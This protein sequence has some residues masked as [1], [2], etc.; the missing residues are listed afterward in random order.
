[1][2]TSLE[3]RFSRGFSAGVH[4]TWSAFIDEASEIFNPSPGE[5]AVSQDSFN[6][7]ADRGRS[8][9]DRPHRFAGNFVYELPWYREQHGFV[10]HVLGGWQINSSFSFQSGAP[11][12]PLNGSDPTGAL[13][14]IDTLVGN[15]IRPNVLST[16][17]MSSMSVE[18][19][20]AAGRFGLFQPYDLASASVMRDETFSALM[21]STTWT[22]EF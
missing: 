4:Y 3:K 8:T 10:G 17:P 7:L 16:L 5:I 1:M 20:V 15:A 18:E 11:F 12:T 14:G 13:S 22:S 9:F 21:V 2:Q 19:L 6:R